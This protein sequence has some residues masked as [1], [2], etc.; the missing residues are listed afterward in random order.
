MTQNLSHEVALAGGD[1]VFQRE[2]RHVRLWDSSAAQRLATD[3]LR[4]QQPFDTFCGRASP[5]TVALAGIVSHLG[6]G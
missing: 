6:A 5:T 3:Y 4:A 2:S 1:A